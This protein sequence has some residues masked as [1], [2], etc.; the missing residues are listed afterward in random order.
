M[1]QIPL[2][3]KSVPSAPSFQPLYRQIKARLTERLSAGEWRPGEPIP[4][5]IELAQRFS[6][7]QGTV[8]KAVGELADE[9][10]LVRRQGRG[11]FVASH[12]H[13]RAQLSFLRLAPDDD[14]VRTIEAQLLDL[15]RVRADAGSARQL[16]LASGASLIRLRRTLAIN[17]E[18]M[19]FEEARVPADLFLGLDADVVERHR[20]MLYSMYESAY[21]VK[22]VAAEERLKSVSAD[23]DIASILGVETGAPLLLMERVAYTYDRKP[24]ELRRGFCNTLRHHYAN[25]IT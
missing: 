3:M 16:E 9:N 21:H 5:E 10:V 20:C 7:S 23:A 18:C 17:G 15:R 13:A 24:V 4:S 8:R 11:T 25:E 12:A 6:V 22:I 1:V 2:Q 19:L 14:E